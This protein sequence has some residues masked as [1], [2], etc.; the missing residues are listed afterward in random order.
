MKSTG[1]RALVYGHA[2][3]NLIDGS[4]VW[5]Q[6]ATQV[7]SGAGC[8]VTL[9]LKARVTTERLLE[10][11]LANERVT[12]RRPWEERLVS[13]RGDKD[14]MTPGE[15][16]AVIRQLDKENSYDLII[17]RGLQITKALV[18]EGRYAGRLWPYLTDIAQTFDTMNQ[19]DI[20]DLRQ[21]VEASRLLLCQTD[22]LRSFLETN[23]PEACGRTT[24]FPPVVPERGFELPVQRRSPEDP[25]RLVYMGKYAPDWLTLEMTR[26]PARLA[27]RGHSV[28]VHMIGDKIHRPPGN[29]EYEQVMHD[30]LAN[31]PGVVWHG[32]V[33]R[34]KA[35]QLAAT[36]DVGLSWRHERLDESLELSTKLLEYG[37]LG[38]P[39]VLNRN[40]MH[41]VLLG[42]DYPMFADKTDVVDVLDA[43]LRDE[44]LR[45]DAAQRCGATVEPHML[46]RAIER[47][48]AVL[49]EAFP[50]VPE[51]ASRRR[52][53]RVLVASHDF[54]FFTRLQEHLSALPG[55]ELKID[56]WTALNEH[57]EK[58]SERLNKWADVVICE[59]LGPNAAWYSKN[60]RPGQRLIV[61]LHRFEVYRRYPRNVVIS[62]VDQVVCVSPHYAAITRERTGWPAEKIVVIP[63]WVD[64]GQLDRPKLTDSEY[65]LGFIGIAPMARKRLGLALDVLANLRQRDQRFQLAIKTKM[66]WGYPWIWAEEV[67]KQLTTE[68]LRRIHHDEALRGAVVFDPFGPDVG[69]FLRRVGYVLSTSDDESFHLAP[70]EGMASGAVPAILNWP[71]S[72][73]IYSSRWIHES[74]EDM[75]QSIWDTTASGE[76][77]K[78]GQEAQDEVRAAF[79][80]P[81][82]GA[83]WAS[84]LTRNLQQSP[85]TLA[86]G[87]PVRATPQR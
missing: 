75:A 31:T 51:L 62:A 33:S 19:D 73:T 66:T 13:G 85:T 34:S 17:V 46:G 87:A 86:V 78:I 63:N 20:D 49:S 27:E 67:E 64:L 4:A 83:Q 47:T 71:G 57:D 54:K 79:S 39:V 77:H 70:A 29:P 9:L 48:K 7:F 24:W 23:V 15:A 18:A 6:S 14:S 53:L 10:P 76:W 82:V 26:L 40:P 21:I 41:E 22:E 84:I 58:Q 35:W 55:V 25:F 16:A 32:G 12:I 1:I 36:C 37:Q 5:V 56:R 65:T 44:S 60:K 59:W 30:A 61:R 52:P 81:V 45:R 68:A 80:L 50:V 72:D 28:E 43:A 42:P 3:M 11:L 2:D 74:V 38:L 69:S 8:D